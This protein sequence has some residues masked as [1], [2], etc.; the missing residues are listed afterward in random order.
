MI[1]DISHLSAAG[2]AHLGEI[3]ARPFVASH[4]SCR[5]L[6]DHPRNLTDAQIERVAASGGFVA[7]NAFGPFVAEAEP[8][9]DGFIDHLEHAAAVA[10]EDR[11]AVGAD[12]IEDLISMVDPIL[13]RQILIDPASLTHTDGLSAPAD[14]PNLET[15][16]IE[17]LGQDRAARFAS[18]NMLDFFRANLKDAEDQ[19]VRG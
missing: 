9:I 19:G 14:Y 16:L 5:A 3:A 17:R 12:F 6:C 4:S 15:R 2:V 13:S 7:M 11:V 1:V 10:G 8:T 18:T